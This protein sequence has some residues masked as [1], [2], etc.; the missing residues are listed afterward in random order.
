[1]ETT[2]GKTLRQMFDDLEELP[3]PITPEPRKPFDTAEQALR[4][5]SA[6]KAIVTL[7]SLKTS[8]RF[9]FKVAAPSHADAQAKADELRFVGVLTGSNN[10][11]DYQYIGF[12]RRGIFHYGRKSKLAESVA[13]VRA[14]TWAWRELSR[15]QMPQTLRVWHEGRC[16][17]C[18]KTLTVP[19]S[20]ET[21]FGPE[22]QGKMGLGKAAKATAKA[23]AK[24][25]SL[26]ELGL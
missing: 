3:Q 10:E 20:I 13:S 16:G 6:G 12:V 18:G 15:G 9:T 24:A 4:F 17:R 1:M 2:T 22:C 14:F 19:E 21:G 11:T 26:E 7:E 23:T 25:Y 5:M 8:N